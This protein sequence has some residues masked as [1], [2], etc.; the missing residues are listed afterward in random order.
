VG[1]TIVGV[2][3]P[4]TTVQHPARAILDDTFAHLMG[5]AHEAASGY[6]LRRPPTDAQALANNYKKSPPVRVLG[7]VIKIEN[8]YGTYRSGTAPDGTRWSNRMAAHY[9]D[10]VGSRG[11][12]GD[13]VDIFVG[14]FPE[15][16]RVWVI[17]QRR[18][19][20]EFDEHKVMAGF[21][22]EEQARAAYLGS[23]DRGWNGL[24]S[25]VACT[26]DQ[27]KWWLRYGDCTVRFNIENLPQ[28]GTAVMDNIVQWDE[29]ANPVGVPMHRLLYDLHREDGAAGLMFD[30]VTM[31]D[32]MGDPDIESVAVLDALVVQ[33]SRMTIKMDLLKKVMEAAGDKVKPTEVTIS[34]PVR[35][36]GV[37]QVMVLF[38]M[39]DGQTI[40]IWFHNP[41]TT[42][43]KLTPMDELIS[44]K[45][46]LNKKDVTIVVAPERGQE[47]NIREVARRIMRLVERNSAAFL[48]AN[49]K[50]AERVAQVEA[51]KTEI[52]GLESELADLTRQIE[53][54]KVAA[55]PSITPKSPF[56]LEYLRLKAQNPEAVLLYR[57]GDFYEVLGESAAL[58]A[59]VLDLTLTRRGAGKYSPVAM[60]GIPA[61]TLQEHMKRLT[62]A[63]YAVAVSEAGPEGART[64]DRVEPAKVETPAAVAA[65][66]EPPAQSAPVEG[67][68]ARDAVLAECG[69]AADIIA[70][71]ADDGGYAAVVADDKLV[72]KWQDALD[73]ALQ[74]RMVNVRNALREMDWKGSGVSLSKAF[75]GSVYGITQ[76]V[77]QVGAGANVVAVTWVLNGVERVP[78]NLTE[79]AAALAGTLNNMVGDMAKP[80]GSAS[81]DVNNAEERGAMVE[82]R[83][84]AVKAALRG[85]GWS[86]DTASMPLMKAGAK[87]EIHVA[88]DQGGNATGTRFYVTGNTSRTA[89]YGRDGM[90][91]DLESS[92][93][94][95]A[96]LLNAEV[97]PALVV[98]NDDGRSRVAHASNGNPIS[99]SYPTEAEAQ[100]AADA[101]IAAGN[102]EFPE[103]SDGGRPASP[104]DAEI[105]AAAAAG[106]EVRTLSRNM[107]DFSLKD[108]NPL[109]HLSTDNGSVSI[110]L[111]TKADVDR[112][113]RAVAEAEQ[114][115]N[116]KPFDMS[117]LKMPTAVQL[118]LN[119]SNTLILPT[120][121]AD[122]N[123]I[124]PGWSNGHLMD[125]TQRPTLV[126]N[127]IAK[128]FVDTGSALIRRVPEAAVAKI[129][130]AAKGRGTKVEPIS[131][132]DYEERVVDNRKAKQGRAIEYIPRE[133]LVLSNE[134]GS[135]WV[136]LE[137]KYVAY[138][139][140]TYKGCEFFAEGPEV[141]VGVRHH[142]KL[143]GVLMPLRGKNGSDML[144]RARKAM[145]SLPAETAQPE[146]TAVAP[147]SAADALAAV[148]AA[149]RFA[150]ATPAF[151][152]DVFHSLGESSYSPFVSART[153]DQRAKELGLTV[154][155][156]VTM[157]V[158][159]GVPVDGD[160]ASMPL[161][162]DADGA[163]LNQ[164]K[165]A[166]AATAKLVK[167]FRDFIRSDKELAID[168]T[169]GWARSTMTK[170]D[171]QRILGEL[172]DI[173]VNRKGGT[174]LTAQQEDDYADFAHDA[175]LINDYLSKRIRHSGSR[176]LLRH[177]KMKALYPHIDNQPFLDA[178][179]A[180]AQPL[181][182]ADAVLDFAGDVSAAIAQLE[183]AL[184]V[185][186]TNEPINR[187]RGDIEQADLERRNAE[188]FRRAIE[189]LKKGDTS[190]IFDDANPHTG[191]EQYQMIVGTIRR[192]GEVIGRALIGG[193]GKA[194]VYVGASGN[195][196]VTFVSPVDGE[197]R[198]PMW[199]DDDA[200]EM[201]D[202]LVENTTVGGAGVP[203]ADPP[204]AAPVVDPPEKPKATEAEG[205]AALRQIADYMPRGQR[206]AIEAGMAGEEAQFFYDKM[207][208]MARNIEA[209][210]KT[211]DT[212]G[213]GGKALAR[214]HYFRGGADWYITERDRE[215]E[216]VQ[217][218]GLADLG[219]GYPESGY[220]SIVELVQ[221]GV[222]LD[223]HWEPKTLDE[224]KGT[225]SAS[226]AQPD[227]GPAGDISYRTDGMFTTFLPDSKAGEKAWAIMN[228]TPGSE[229]GK[230]LAA[231]TE[232]VIAQLRAAGFVVTEAKPVDMSADELAAELGA[233]AATPTVMDEPAREDAKVTERK[234]DEAYLQ[235]MINGK[236]DLLED[237]ILER[238]EPMFTKYE[239]DAEMM[240]LLERAAQ[241]YS[242][243]ATQAAR[244]ALAS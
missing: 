165:D 157:T 233:G 11:A 195:Q 201:V 44:W 136:W 68:A 20:G 114:Q 133:S 191:G 12:D 192:A 10:I 220:I 226:E 56:E 180:L 171:A 1:K 49:A 130:A 230:V 224:I 28:E 242:D 73:S 77:R 175:R 83:V 19:D 42:P 139:V 32:L 45:W 92:P 47:L 67:N 78:D 141:S 209:M 99:P 46:M 208:E 161:F 115:A 125:F 118:G 54:A 206:K 147:D 17:N 223:L 16:R 88:R 122:G 152:E 63:G 215:R 85:L 188:Q 229:S 210:P 172:I 156:D 214:L 203:P 194:M 159:D 222:E 36:R 102:L 13:P 183:V 127:A 189:V 75:A 204:A 176:N 164:S 86:S 163:Y 34:D 81:A 167:Y 3:Y 65:P 199:S 117:R 6:N 101:A 50:T 113:A 37:L 22:T 119:K 212:D 240:A 55:E 143:V 237:G 8:A 51:I 239:G 227:V 97:G 106:A 198:T 197:R 196:R 168:T 14:P 84:E 93:V 64:V 184:D 61:W 126:Q 213:Q 35:A 173:A 235:N 90:V 116:Y 193:D 94:D 79:K 155:W 40:S 31:T 80:V 185:V 112:A 217:A 244:A 236:A 170:A 205:R 146:P 174:T 202:W 39:T 234:T 135:V 153:I 103:P 178:V 131:H 104:T 138:F 43:A 148:D 123:E 137:S 74:Q 18:A 151:K 232:S 207:V 33:V 110:A 2:T 132:Y 145:I 120:G 128:Y 21:M 109:A 108:Q 41:D 134:N 9:G 162:D 96:A 100:A 166:I 121:G 52:A 72:L 76:E 218:F 7:L 70:A 200:G 4:Q 140:K 177:P 149:Y 62:A 57:M 15:S 59:K 219:G 58:V 27:L 5:A 144:A 23:Y 182:P 243:A 142:G 87:L 53:I 129:E 24:G 71:V 98:V 221:N 241:A 107:A 187:E 95:L 89:T 186:V 238:I 82:S 105:E 190:G 48:R 29:D 211:Y 25:I 69:M 231:H 216:Q 158:L 66:A 179:K 181:L 91:D 169:S 225:A 60:V 160:D 154:G 228:A 111:W 150:D 124:L 30:A 38:Q 26:P